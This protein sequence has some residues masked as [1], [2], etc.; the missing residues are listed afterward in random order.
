MS[1]CAKILKIPES[2]EIYLN[3]DK[4]A[5]IYPTLLI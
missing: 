5:S 4:Y 2:A 1:N 3:V